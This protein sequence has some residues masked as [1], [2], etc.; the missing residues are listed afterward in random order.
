MPF[1]LTKAPQLLWSLD[2]PKVLNKYLDQFMVVY[3]D[4]IVVFSPNLEEDQVHL[5]SIL[6]V[7]PILT[8]L[9]AEHRYVGPPSNSSWSFFLN[10]EE[11]RITLLLRIDK[12]SSSPYFIP[13]S[14]RVPH[15]SDFSSE[16]GI[17]SSYPRLME[18]PSSN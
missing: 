7:I 11:E 9:A 17:D 8:S 16:P 10:I 18:H 13:K 1:G 14:E 4:D 3:L 12:G 15:L 2:E 6:F 5:R